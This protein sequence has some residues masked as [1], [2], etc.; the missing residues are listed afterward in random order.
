MTLKF[1]KRSKA[2]IRKRKREK[3]E[4]NKCGVDNEIHEIRLQERRLKG[5]KRRDLFRKNAFKE[6]RRSKIEVS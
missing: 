1:S 6:R 2:A 4:R 5:R 3:N